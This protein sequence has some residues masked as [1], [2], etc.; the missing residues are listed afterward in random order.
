MAVNK[1][2]ENVVGRLGAG[3]L[4]FFFYCLDL[5]FGNSYFSKINIPVKNINNVTA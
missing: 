5:S 1:P 2:R 4:F 3:G